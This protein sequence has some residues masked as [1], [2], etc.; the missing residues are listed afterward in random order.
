MAAWVV[1]A[2]AVLVAG[3]AV[4]PG[5]LDPTWGG[6]GVVTLDL[7]TD[8]WADDVVATAAGGVVVAGHERDLGAVLVR[9]R[10]DGRLD[11]TFGGGDGVVT[12][13]IG[14]Q[15]TRYLAL[16]ALADGGLVAAGATHVPGE[17]GGDIL[18][19]RHRP[20]GTLDPAFGGDGWVTVPVDG[21]Q[22]AKAVAAA[23]DGRVVVVAVG[24]AGDADVAVRLTAAGAPD[25]S[26]GDDGVVELPGDPWDVVVAPDARIVVAGQSGGDA[27]LVA[28]LPD[29]SPDPAFGVGGVATVDPYAT[30]GVFRGVA[31]RGDGFVATGSEVFN[32]HNHD[33]LVAAFDGEGEV[34]PA[35]D[36]DGIVV[37]PF[38]NG[39]DTGR[40]VVVQPDGRVLVLALD[41]FQD[42]PPYLL[43]RY[44]PGGRPD[45]TFAG[46]G[47]LRF[48]PP[49]DGFWS[50]ALTPAGAV[51]AGSEPEHG[52]AVVRVVL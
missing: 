2:A 31:V 47:V 35:F 11:R 44:R 50:L 42:G 7:G 51:T 37:E 43:L 28:L 22:D 21:W 23:D 4:S 15:E 5:T 34:D 32:Q 40:D 17:T 26:F 36:G 18:V 3:A 10:R 20:D 24:S 13:R 12:E 9:Y 48:G 33:V 19:A 45:R 16:A 39:F 25:P 29:G 1:A 41:S 8:Q 52:I 30:G 6:D 27:A 14:D 38:G 46:T 49:Y